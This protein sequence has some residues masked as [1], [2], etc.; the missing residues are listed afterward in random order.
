MSH[1]CAA[2]A[3]DDPAW[4]ADDHLFHPRRAAVRRVRRDAGHGGTGRRCGAA[5]GDRDVRPDPVADRAPR[6][7]AAA[8]RRGRGAR[9]GPEPDE[10]AGR[11]RRADA[12]HSAV[13]GVAPACR[14]FAVSD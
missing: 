1:V 4:P 3:A 5:D 13:G 7:A 2:S 8:H 12:A 14:G 6:A 10:H 11:A 9:A